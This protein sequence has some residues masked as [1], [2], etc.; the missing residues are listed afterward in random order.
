MMIGM[1]FKRSS[2]RIIV[3][4]SKPSIRGISISSS[5]TSGTSS[6]S[7][8]I[9]STPSFAVIT[10]YWWRCSKRAVTLRTVIESSTTITVGIRFSCA[11]SS[12]RPASWAKSHSWKRSTK[13]CISRI[14]TTVPSPVIE[15]PEI[16]GTVEIWR[17]TF[18]TIISREPS[19]SS[20]WTA[21]GLPSPW[22]INTG[23]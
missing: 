1:C 21:I 18:F 17:P 23:T 10:W 16:P 7:C 19:N 15:A 5:M 20:T 3:A 13:V 4:N 9:A 8:V 11:T 12:T 22:I 6:C 14:N 2:W